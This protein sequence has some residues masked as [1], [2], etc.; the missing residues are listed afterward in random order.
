MYTALPTIAACSPLG[1]ALPKCGGHAHPGQRDAK[2]HGGRGRH[3]ALVGWI[4][5]PLSSLAGSPFSD[6]T[7]PAV[8]LTAAVG[9]TA[10]LAAWL[11]HL[12]M[13]LGIPASAIAGAAIIIFEIV[14]WNVIG[15][16]WLQA[17]YIG[18]GAAILGLATWVRMAD[19]LLHMPENVHPRAAR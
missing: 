11:V 2:P 1:L 10:L 3:R 7:V 8:L 12:R 19:V 13:R 15:F 14:E 16:A 17:A 4:N 18:I 5:V 9:G 6:Y